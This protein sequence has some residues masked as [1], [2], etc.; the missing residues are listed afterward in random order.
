VIN[1]GEGLPSLF[2]IGH[3]R[4]RNN[5]ALKLVKIERGVNNNGRSRKI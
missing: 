1:N 4:I 5:D 3:S 2:A